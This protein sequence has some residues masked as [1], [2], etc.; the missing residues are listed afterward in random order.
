MNVKPKRCRGEDG[1][2]LQELLIAMVISTIIVTPL[3]GAIFTSLHTASSTINRT[4]QSVGANLLSTYF[5]TDVQNAV[6]VATGVTEPTSVCGSGVTT[7]TGL[8]LTT[9][10]TAGTS[11]TF[12]YQGAGANSVFL[13]RQTCAQTAG[14]GTSAGKVLPLVQQLSAAPQFTCVPDCTN[15]NWQSVGVQLTQSSTT[16]PGSYTTTVQASRRVS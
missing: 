12:Y 15:T 3:A 5:G 10:G 9:P 16:F 4:Q 7:Q 2:T 1:L 13:Y 11:T 14:G 6:Q 8:L